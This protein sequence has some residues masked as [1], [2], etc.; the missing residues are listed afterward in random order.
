MEVVGEFFGVLLYCWGGMGAT[1]CF[2]V[3]AA[4]GEEGYGSLLN[5]A[6]CYTFA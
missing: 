5:I 1:A 2:F 3:T 4:S 6:L